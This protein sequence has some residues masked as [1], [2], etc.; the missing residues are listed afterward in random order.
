MLPY[1]TEINWC[2]PEPIFWVA[3][4]VYSTAGSFVFFFPSHHLLWAALGVQS[5]QTYLH[6]ATMTWIKQMVIA[7]FFFFSCHKI[8]SGLHLK[9]RHV[10]VLNVCWFQKCKSLF[11]FFFLTPLAAYYIIV[12]AYLERQTYRPHTDYASSLGIA[13]VNSCISFQVLVPWKIY[14]YRLYQDLIKWCL[15]YEWCAL[16]HSPLVL[17]LPGSVMPVATFSLLYISFFS[18]IRFLD[19]SHISLSCMLDL[20]SIVCSSA[21]LGNQ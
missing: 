3:M 2:E 16:G 11:F 17:C 7:F 13:N 9:F 21:S 10:R 5:Y 20:E 14:W 15:G 19:C 4:C 18:E 1:K 12:L 6:L 8:C